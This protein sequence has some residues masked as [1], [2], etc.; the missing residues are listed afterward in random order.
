MPWLVL[1]LLQILFL[2]YNI[3]IYI[4]TQCNLVQYLNKCTESTI[5]VMLLFLYNCMLKFTIFCFI[6]LTDC[7]THVLLL[8]SNNCRFGRACPCGIP[9]WW[10][11]ICGATLYAAVETGTRQHRSPV[12]AQL[13]TLPAEKTRQVCLGLAMCDINLYNLNIVSSTVFFGSFSV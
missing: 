4:H 3:N 1:S 9:V 7:L 2:V 6:C 10:L 11:W 8:I 13:H 12:A 5:Y